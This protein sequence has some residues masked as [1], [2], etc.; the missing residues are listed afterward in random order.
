MLLGTTHFGPLFMCWSIE[1]CGTMVDSTFRSNPARILPRSGCNLERSEHHPRSFLDVDINNNRPQII[2]AIYRQS[3]QIGNRNH[4]TVRS[5][6]RANYSNSNYRCLVTSSTFLHPET[7]V[8]LILSIPGSLPP[9]GLLYAFSWSFVNSS[10]VRLSDGANGW[11]L[12]RRH[13][14][15]TRVCVLW[16]DC[17][18]HHFENKNSCGSGLVYYRVRRVSHRGAYYHEV[19]HTAVISCKSRWIARQK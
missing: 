12:L 18:T 7:S 1:K 6:G 9:S 17:G 14:G 10:A 19:A 3:I 15:Y 16:N 2:C 13:I 4:G 11:F 8:D 5:N